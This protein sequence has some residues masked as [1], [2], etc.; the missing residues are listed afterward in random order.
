MTGDNIGTTVVL[1]WD[2]LDYQLLGEYGLL[3]S[4]CEYTEPIETYRNEH[5][6]E[7]H[8]R[9]IWPTMI[10]GVSPEEHGIWAAREGEG[11]Q[12]RHPSIRA[13]SRVAQY[14]IPE[15]IKAVIGRWL[16]SQGAEVEK[17]ESDYYRDQGLET[18]FD[19]RRSLSIAVPNY[20][21]ELD[22]KNN[23]MFDRGAELGQWLD[24]DEDGWHPAD[25]SQ[26][27]RLE[28][29]MWSE[30]GQKLALVEHAIQH[31]YD[32][33]WVWFGIVDTCGHVEPAATRPVQQRAYEQAVEWTERI[34]GQLKSNDCLIC[35]SDHGLR[36]GHHTMDA[37]L[38]TDEETVANRVD[39]VYDVKAAIDA[40]TP[41]RDRVEMPPLGDVHK[42]KQKSSDA[43]AEEVRGRL[44]DLGYV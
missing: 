29:E 24:R 31:Q 14:T 11:V 35:V 18:V 34:R 27:A 38:S 30:A 37:T 42:S 4:F 33:V 3:D 20:R 2:A 5:I 6:G 1:G 41:T 43:T 25:D 40:V 13:A 23:F 17:Y 22:D 21:T 7:P 28:R 39:S 19:G 15:D 32:L 8:T 10:T 44:E 26:Q 16:R 36:E 12:W 9:E